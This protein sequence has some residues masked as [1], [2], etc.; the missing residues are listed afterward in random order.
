VGCCG[1]FKSFNHFICI[2]GVV[3]VKGRMYAL[4][5]KM[6]KG[7]ILSTSNIES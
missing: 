3:L 4:A 6:Y 5:N 7:K 1:G 2:D